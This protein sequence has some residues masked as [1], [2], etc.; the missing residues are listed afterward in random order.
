VGWRLGYI[1]VSSR[2]KWHTKYIAVYKSE[3]NFSTHRFHEG[4]PFS[5][6]LDG[7]AVDWQ[8]LMRG[9]CPVSDIVPRLGFWKC[10][11]K[12]ELLS[13]NLGRTVMEE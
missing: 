6:G 9:N 4:N 2:G 3:K 7:K 12:Y 8:V 1:I 11:R 13:V 5:P 10:L